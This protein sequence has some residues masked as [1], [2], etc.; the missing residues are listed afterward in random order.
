MYIIYQ[1][2]NRQSNQQ[3]SVAFVA[4]ESFKDPTTKKATIESIVPTNAKYVIVPRLNI[5]FDFFDAYEFDE[6]EGAIPNPLKSQDKQRNFWRD[7][8]KPLL[9]K[10]DLKYLKADEEGNVEEK[11]NII[12]EKRKLRDVT[13]TELPEDL[14]NIRRVWPE[15]LGEDP[16]GIAFRSK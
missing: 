14:Q 12:E 2:S 9:E 16:F 8:R 10:L 1:Q 15:I 5:D 6:N 4:R 11:N 7:A 3:I 13:L